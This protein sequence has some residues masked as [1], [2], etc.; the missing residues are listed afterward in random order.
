VLGVPGAALSKIDVVKLTSI[1]ICAGAGGQALGLEQAGFQHLAVVEHDR[2]ACATLRINRPYWDVLREDVTEWKATRYRGKVDL[3][4][5]GVPC[6][7][8]SKAGKQLGAGDERDLFPHAL[9]LVRQCSPRAVMLENVRGLLDR[10]FRDYRRNLERELQEDGYTC[11]WK[12]H[13]AS[14]HGVPQLRPRTILVALR[15]RA[16][17][18][19]EWPKPRQSPAPTVGEVLYEWMAEAGWEGAEAWAARA[20]KIAPTLVGGSKKHGGPD[21]GP[22]RARREWAA[23]GV[24]G[25]VLANQPP[26]P[27][28]AGTPSLTVEMAAAIQGFSP[29]WKFMGPKTHAY[30]QVGNAFPPP[31]AR[32]VGDAIASALRKA[33]RESP[34]EL[35][36]VAA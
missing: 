20:S 12:L 23:L 19:F 36:T 3:F 31:V 32:A 22:S 27:G 5:G 30:R 4:A 33:G 17:K 14:D 10:V 1:E 6:P 11:F 29:D 9:R 7:P 25:K 28:F 16:V 21:L 24:N 2:H 13:H 26:P 34:H 35:E 18:H 8:F 15:G